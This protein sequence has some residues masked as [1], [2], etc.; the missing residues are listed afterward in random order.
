MDWKNLGVASGLGAVTG[1]ILFSLANLAD[2]SYY[3][4][5]YG[6]TPVVLSGMAV[7]AAVGGLGMAVQS[8]FMDRMNYPLIGGATGAVTTMGVSK[9]HPTWRQNSNTLLIGRSLIVGGVLVAAGV[10]YDLIKNN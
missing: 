5:R 9:L 4:D 8:R 7:G 10:G 6:W 3:S 1:G 2:S